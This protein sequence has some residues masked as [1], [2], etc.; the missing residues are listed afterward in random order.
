MDLHLPR[1]ELKFAAAACQFVGPL[2][3]NVNGRVTRRYLFDG[4]LKVRQNAL[5]IFQPH[6]VLIR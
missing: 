3:V 6:G 4:S 5:Q 2:A 1:R